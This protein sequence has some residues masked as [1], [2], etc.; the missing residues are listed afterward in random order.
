MSIHVALH[1]RTTYRYAR[2]VALGPQ[3]VRLRPAP[4][5]RTRILSYSQKVL[6]NPHFINWQQDPQANYVAR[7]IFP[8][9]T[10]ELSIVVDLVAEMAAINPF[11]FF[12]EPHA[13]KWPFEYE[14]ALRDDLAPYRKLLTPSPLLDAYVARISREPRG[15]NDL[16]VSLNRELCA[17]ID[18]RVRLESGLQTPDETLE[19]RSGSCRDSGW[20]LVQI[21]R[22]LGFAARF[23]SGYLIQLTADTKPLEGPA[24]PTSDFVDLHAWCEVYLPGA[25]WIGYDPTSGLLAGEGHLPLACTAEPALAAPVSGLVDAV[26]TSFEH[27]M[28]VQRVLEVPRVTKPY[29]E[30]QWQA[31]GALGHTIDAAL[32]AGDVRLTM[33]GEPTFIAADDLDGAEWNTAALGPNKRRLSTDLFRRMKSRYAPKGLSH[34]GQGKWYPGEPLPPNEIPLR[35]EGAFA[36]RARQVVSRRAAASLVLEPVLAKRW[37]GALDRSQA[38]RRRSGAERRG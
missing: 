4:H 18:Y 25:G 28:K 10:S 7:L 22:R 15:T 12:L 36:F 13:E 24:G 26:E 11:D 23:V 14:A 31:I 29:S 21:L 8:E 38:G 33:G 19:K 3:T 2:P 34:F 27:E 20:L 17:H 6:P 1:H 35:P 30:E 16:L 9:R 5:C 32:A 37:G